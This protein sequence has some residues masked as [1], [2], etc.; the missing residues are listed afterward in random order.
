MSAQRTKPFSI[1]LNEAHIK[2]VK[3]T[4]TQFDDWKPN[5]RRYQKNVLL[6]FEKNF[7]L[8]G[9][10]E[11]RQLYSLAI[12][13]VLSDPIIAKDESTLA[14]LTNRKLALQK[15]ETRTN[16]WR[17]YWKQPKAHEDLQ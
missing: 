1:T 3:E 12:Q 16:E 10:Q 2:W 5:R 15:S 6:E 9:Q 13:H 7:Q 14:K 8:S 17:Q 11:A 4:A